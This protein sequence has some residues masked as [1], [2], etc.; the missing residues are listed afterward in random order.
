MSLEPWAGPEQVFFQVTRPATHKQSLRMWEEVGPEGDSWGAWT[1]QKSMKAGAWC[2]IYVTAPDMKFAWIA[3]SLCDSEQPHRTGTS[4]N[5]FLELYPLSTPLSL[6]DAKSLPGL[7]GWGALTNMQGT[8]K[9]ITDL[10]KWATLIGRICELNPK[11]ADLLEDWAEDEPVRPDEDL[12][13]FYW[14]GPAPEGGY[15]FAI[16]RGRGGLQRWVHDAAIAKGWRPMN[17]D[18]LPSMEARLDEFGRADI[19]LQFPPTPANIAPKGLVVE[20]KKFASRTNGVEQLSRYR[21]WFER[22][23]PDWE[24][25]YEL[26][27]QEFS[28]KSIDA[29]SAD[30]ISISRV[31]FEDPYLD[32]MTSDINRVRIFDRHWP[33]SEGVVDEQQ[34]VLLVERLRSEDRVA[35]G[36]FVKPESKDDRDCWLVAVFPAPE[37]VGTWRDRLESDEVESDWTLQAGA[38]PDPYADFQ[39]MGYFPDAWPD[40]EVA[41]ILLSE[42]SASTVRRALRRLEPGFDIPVSSAEDAERVKYDLVDGS[43]SVKF[44]C[45]LHEDGNPID[46]IW[47]QVLE[48]IQD[49]GYDITPLM[50]RMS[51]RRFWEEYND[52]VDRIIEDFELLQDVTQQ[53]VTD[54]DFEKEWKEK[55]EAEDEA[56]E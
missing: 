19:V 28:K 31:R 22:E 48:V 33:S 27:A 45:E 14:S 41:S 11:V 47:F 50:G 9:Q 34:A 24:M 52:S 15:P 21:Q 49:H 38:T 32:F 56:K 25:V 55:E 7:S 4:W 13:D 17:D 40:C 51:E 46:N 43:V 26:V 1:S 23:M 8:S 35:L 30:K 42:E 6:A 16:E 53:R 44:G 2:L 3:R 36:D 54:E 18:R 39:Y 5:T 10:D 12:A 20:T 29:A 37:G